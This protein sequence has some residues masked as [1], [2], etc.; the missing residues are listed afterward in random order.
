MITV[1]QLHEMASQKELR[2]KKKRRTVKPIRTEV[3]PEEKP[4]IDTLPVQRSQRI[5]SHSPGRDEE[6]LRKKLT[7][8]KDLPMKIQSRHRT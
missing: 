4:E 6:A 8:A 7:L 2:Q 1:E 3:L 5:V